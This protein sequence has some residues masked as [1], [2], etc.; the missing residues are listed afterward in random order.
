MPVAQATQT[1]AGIENENEF[2][3]HH[4][5]AEV[6]YGN[7]R[8]QIDRWQKAEEEEG[9]AKA[10]HSQLRS[11]ASRWY[12]Q[13]LELAKA[14]DDADRLHGFRQQQQL[15]LEALGYAIQPVE[16]ELHPGMAVPVW[17]C[18]AEPGR[19]PHLV[20]A[21]AYGGSAV[22][23]E[24]AEDGLG[25]ALSPSQ[26]QSGEVPPA[27]HGLTWDSIVSE[28]LF[29][30]DQPPRYVILL[31][32]DEWL[33]LDRFKWPNNRLLRFNWRE[34]LDRRETPTLQAAAALLHRESLV[35]ATG[36]PLLETLEEH[37]HKHAF[38]VSDKLK[39]AIREAIELIGN[40]A[41]QQLRQQ[42]ADAKKG[43]FSGKDE[44]DA[45]QLSLECLRVVYRLLFLFYVESRPELGYVPIQKSE[46]YANG[47]SLEMLR[48]LERIPLNTQQAREGTFFDDS[49][50]LLF[51]LV[52]EGARAAEQQMLSAST[53][54][55][56]FT[57]APL[58]SRLFDPETTPLLNK[59]R[60][61]NWLWQK[62]IE[63]MSLSK[64]EKGRTGRVSYQLLSINQLGAV[65]EA[66]LSYRGFF[67]TEDLYEV[68]PAPKKTKA[69]AGDDDE[70]DEEDGDDAEVGSTQTDL[71]ENAW[72]V[73]ASRI[74]DYKLNERVY[75]RD[76]N[77]NAKLRVHEKG[78]FIYRLAGRD[79]KK[80]A[81]YYTPQV[82]TRCLVKYALKELLPGKTADDILR[83]TVCEPAMGSAAFLNEAVNQLAEAYL[84][85]KQAELNKRI[86][87]DRYA[88]ELQ[89]V[90][91]YIADHN[92]FGVDLN[93]VA[94]ELAEVSLWL[95]AIYGEQDE[96]KAPRPARV[97]WFGYQLFA[98]NSLVGA[99]P[100]VYAAGL[101]TA[102]ANPKW[103]KQA[104][105]RL[106]PQKPDRR[107]DEIYHFLLPDLGM[108]GYKDQTAKALYAK[109]F[110]RLEKWRKEFC[111]PL[112]PHELKLLKEL[113]AVVDDLWQEHAAWLARDR[114]RTEDPLPLWPDGTPLTPSATG[115]AKK[116]EI[117]RQGLWNRDE[118]EATPF[119]RLK[120]V[121]DYWCA[122]WFWP[123]QPEV[124]LP[125]REEWWQAVS[126]ILRGNIV[127]LTV[128]PVFDF[129]ATPQQQSPSSEAGGLLAEQPAGPRLHDR[130][131]NLRI[132]RLREH[133]RHIRQV[134]QIAE[135][136]RFF[137]WELAF[138]DIF[139]GRGG[140]DL[141]LGN[142]PWLKVEWE[143]AGILGEKNP[144]FA[145]RKLSAS[146]INTL[147]A[148]TFGDFPGMQLAWLAELEEAEATQAFLNG[149]QNYP[150]LKGIQTNL[151]KCFLPIGWRI[152][153]EAGVAGFLHPEG[154][155]D[156]PKGGLFREATYSRLRLHFQFQ[157]EKKLFPI[158]N[159]NKFGINI[160]AGPA[161]RL[162]IRH[163]C[164][165]FL[166][167][168]IDANY[169]HDG[170]GPVPGVKTAED[171]WELKGHA[172]R[173]L[174]VDDRTLSLFAKL[175][176]EPGTQPHHARLPALHA[177][178]LI[179]V[180]EKLACYPRRLGDL[181]D[182]YFSTV[183][184]D[185]T[186]AQRDGTIRRDT[187]FVDAASDWVLSGPHFFVANPFHQTPK[188]NCNT[189]RA[190]DIIDLEAI[191]D[192]YLPRTNY[193]PMAD[194]A[195]YLRRTPRVSWVDPG[196]SAPRPVTDYY[197]LAFRRQLSQSGE[198]TLLSAIVPPDVG[199][200]HPV[201][202]FTF[203]DREDLVNFAGQTASVVYDFFIKST[204]RGDLYESTLKL[205]PLLNRDPRRDSRLLALACVASP[206]RSLWENW[207][208]GQEKARSGLQTPWK[209]EAALRAPYARRKALVEID[210]LVAQELGLTLEEL[211]LI[212]RVQFPVMQQYERDTWYDTHG[213]IIFTSSKGL[214]GVGLPRRGS[215][216]TPEL[217]I[218]RPNGRQTKGH[219]GWEDVRNLEAGSRVSVT[220]MDDTL[221]GGPHPRLRVWEAPFITANREED[222]RIAW[223]FFE[224][225]EKPGGEA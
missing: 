221:P 79:R 220:V 206:W 36:A 136:R 209:R 58:D 43:F 40:E 21:S 203:R 107:P 124:P 39:Y 130:F 135:R 72:F 140:F 9:G 131:G 190:Y 129:L 19:A 13:R 224:R 151:Y 89:K 165:L 188:R 96:Q 66:L 199:H 166:P 63:R 158:G 73:P 185:E 111:A 32:V 213:R 173:M 218:E 125:S 90:R 56:V 223:E 121:L 51:R 87:H 183:M 184:F 123:I 91:M 92:V 175:Y 7:I 88:Q 195:E 139:R 1:F 219:F 217:T 62:V 69:A 164:N 163:V 189:H 15:L 182:S 12:S 11:L 84:E 200:I 27:L 127:D 52:R 97:P 31:G 81:S 178:T 10:P 198:R 152:S 137:H 174:D 159:R 106:D 126:A 76:E 103:N 222:Y 154:I 71:L 16:L 59:V 110:E 128:Q 168:T 74:D 86:P 78:K 61:P 115:T 94:V 34:I 25:L 112:Q 176:D 45:G 82:L 142:P 187:G 5:L 68:T 47:Y 93:P 212:Y 18:F 191:P 145:I 4:Y 119:R 65:Y 23:E 150:M 38:S 205:L 26:Y 196:H 138:A 50:R 70:D 95:N 35:P 53:V 201:L 161:S 172:D 193:R 101:T 48:D 64:A 216:S 29:G 67:A 77:G 60:F 100:E 181:G 117:R 120:L 122:L 46:I 75:D 104:P 155:Y 8:D 167:V 148:E 146:E 225:Q 149:V 114:R 186:Y 54:R 207:H 132:S 98:G 33:L 160:Y 116:D 208:V 177:G 83:L 147:R 42:A 30:A 44:L 170:L 2:F 28:A 171:E 156:D 210:V 22:P 118:D 180:L 102:K 99:R 215:R 55:E 49:L 179:E 113:S 105:R 109:E 144:L 108:A 157:N 14:K 133:F 162:R 41:A 24:E 143:E 37:A 169:E 17:Q 134:E 192:E 204:G 194:R 202:S 214:V 80:S 197:R 20:I 211:L 57:L 3:S 153:R 141:I 6:F 85:R